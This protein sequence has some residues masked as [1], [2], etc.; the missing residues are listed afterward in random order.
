MKTAARELNA[1]GPDWPITRVRPIARRLSARQRDRRGLLYLFVEVTGPDAGLAERELVRSLSDRYYATLSGQIATA[2]TQTIAEAHLRLRTDNERYVPEDRQHASLACLVLHEHEIY[3][4]VLGHALLYVVTDAGVQTVAS[5]TAADPLA[6]TGLGA[7]AAP[8]VELFRFTPT[9]RCAF[10]L[11]ADVLADH[12]TPD[13]VWDALC[14]AEVADVATCL[15]EQLVASGVDWGR[16]MV[17]DV[18]PEPPAPA[19]PGQPAPAPDV[20]AEAAAPTDDA[21]AA[22]TTEADAEGEPAEPDA[23]SPAPQPIAIAPQDANLGDKPAWARPRVGDYLVAFLSWL[24]RAYNRTADA[25]SPTVTHRLVVGGIAIL[26]VVAG[27]VIVVRMLQSRQDTIADADVAIWAERKERE[28]LSTTDEAQRVKLLEDANELAKRAVRLRKGDPTPAAMSAR[29][30]LE[31]DTTLRVVR[32]G[33]LTQLAVLDGDPVQLA[34]GGGELFVL[35]QGVDRVYRYPLDPTGLAVVGTTN[36]VIVRKGDGIGD[37]AFE[38]PR[39]MLWVPGGSARPLDALLV[40]DEAGS[41]V[42]Y[43]PGGAEPIKSPGTWV[44]DQALA[45]YAGSVFVLDPRTGALRWLSPSLEGY[46]RPV[47]DYLLPGASAT[48]G[49]AQP[50]VALAADTD[51]YALRTSGKVDR[52]VAGEPAEFDG[53]IAGRLALGKDTT[54]HVQPLAL[55]AFDPA[56]RRVVQWTRAGQ[57]VRQYALPAEPPLVAA[58]LDESR[59]LLYLL[60][61]QGIYQVSLSGDVGPTPAAGETP[62]ARSN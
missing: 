30:Q 48:P 53:R 40:F 43:T 57:F 51:L 8:A 9:A 24:G 27:F 19:A 26:A 55:Y 59:G 6:T 23:P 37:Y 33:G 13:Q 50:S 21:T 28:A 38:R 7:P 10:A 29:I 34:L 61:K 3:M 49:P 5:A 15:S 62:G 36:P 2:L 58:A 60:G 14:A 35:N 22:P 42:E 20:D 12:T 18:D 47:Y 46:D 52:Y 31:L 44:L 17:V 32:L 16:V 25:L 11:G 45:A 41:L 1:I 54:L 39:R 56:N 4:A